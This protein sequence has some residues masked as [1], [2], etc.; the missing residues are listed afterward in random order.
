MGLK[1]PQ[2]SVR[3]RLGAHMNIKYIYNKEELEIIV[4]RCYTIA[5]VCRILKIIP[6]GGNYKTLKN[7]FKLY[8][9]DI[10]HFKGRGWNTGTAFKEFKPKIPLNL[11]LVENSKYTN[12]YRLKL[13]LFSE[14]IKH[15]K[16]EVCDNIKWLGKE[17]PLELHHINGI[18]SDHRLNNLMILCP[19]C[20]A[21]TD[22]YRSKN[23][24]K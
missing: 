7:K 3:I 13:R 18:N 8:N 5:S 2:V 6:S 11:I 14:N 17:I 24:V 23:K 4:K 9:I 10:S 20:H 1:N 21:Q 15:K 16:C 22:N 12:S 19:N